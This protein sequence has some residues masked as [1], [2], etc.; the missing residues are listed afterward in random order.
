MCLKNIEC[1]KCGHKEYYGDIQKCPDWDD[2]NQTCPKLRTEDHSHNGKCPQCNP[3]DLKERFWYK[4]FRY[5][6]LTNH[7]AQLTMLAL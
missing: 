5:P 4:V 3:A 1:F 2:E 7:L 6:L